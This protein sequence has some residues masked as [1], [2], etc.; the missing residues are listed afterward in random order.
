MAVEA[1]TCE[2]LSYR[3][4]SRVCGKVVGKST[5]RVQPQV[6]VPEKTLK[7]EP[8]SALFPAENF[9]EELRRGWEAGADTLGPDPDVRT[10]NEMLKFAARVS[11]MPLPGNLLVEVEQLYGVI[12]PL[13]LNHL[14]PLAERLFEIAGRYLR[15]RHQEYLGMTARHTKGQLRRLLSSVRE[16]DRILDEVSVSVFGIIE[17]AHAALE[18][19]HGRPPSLKIQGLWLEMT[20]LVDAVSWLEQSI[21][22]AANRPTNAMQKRALADASKAIQEAS[23]CH[24]KTRWIKSSTS[25]V[26]AFKNAPGRVLFDFMKLLTPDA[27][28][29]S[30]V[31]GFRET[32]RGINN[33]S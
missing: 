2:P 13:A 23:G 24:I 5:F 26:D 21:V 25:S 18:S 1:V 15:P 9:W 28:E 19:V 16:A 11:G 6:I 14:S 32:K 3:T 4:F 33:P 20:H 29:A 17:Q 7:N 22:I 30:L 10:R 31:R 12:E 8:Q 27:S